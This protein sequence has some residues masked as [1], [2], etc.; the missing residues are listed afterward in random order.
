MATYVKDVGELADERCDE[1]SQ[2]DTEGFP[3]PQGERAWVPHWG[4]NCTQC[5]KYC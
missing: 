5:G 3:L 4:G 2:F 1:H